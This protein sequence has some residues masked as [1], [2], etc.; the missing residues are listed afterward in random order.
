MALWLEVDYPFKNLPIP[1]IACKGK[2]RV[3]D[4]GTV[5]SEKCKVCKGTGN[6]PEAQRPKIGAVDWIEEECSRG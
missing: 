1:C 2:G 3:R 6:A 5:W 4:T